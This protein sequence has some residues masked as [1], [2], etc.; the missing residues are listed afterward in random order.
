MFSTGVIID[1]SMVHKSGNII[2]I[3][4]IFVIEQ[5]QQPQI[6]F[7]GHI[8]RNRSLVKRHAIFFS[9]YAC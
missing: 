6:S 7:E 1:A 3:T 9:F 2:I 4:G 5:Q 8:W